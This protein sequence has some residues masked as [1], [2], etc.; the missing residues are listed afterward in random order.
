MAS[1]SKT[2]ML[3]LKMVF[4]QPFHVKK[5]DGPS[6]SREASDFQSRSR[7]LGKA[8]VTSISLGII[9]PCYRLHTVYVC[10]HNSVTH[11]STAR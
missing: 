9:S 6:V 10:W 4:C 2:E 5:T 11:M 3:Y 1:V 8:I 7:S